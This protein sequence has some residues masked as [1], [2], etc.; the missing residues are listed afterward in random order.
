MNHRLILNYK[1]R[2]DQV[3]VLAII[4]GL[5]DALDEAGL[6]L[7]ADVRGWKGRKAG[8]SMSKRAFLAALLLGLGRRRLPD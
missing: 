4:Q 5:L 2:F 6:K 8:R 7:P 1:A 3:G